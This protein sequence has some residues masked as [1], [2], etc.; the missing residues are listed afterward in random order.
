MHGRVFAGWLVVVGV[1]S[2][3]FVLVLG[4][5]YRCVLLTGRRVDALVILQGSLTSHFRFP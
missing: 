1:A 4:G 2:H 5:V 3:G